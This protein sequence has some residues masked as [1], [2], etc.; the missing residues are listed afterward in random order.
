MYVIISLPPPPTK[1]PYY[2]PCMTKT[3]SESRGTYI[4]Y[5]NDHQQSCFRRQCPSL[6]LLGVFSIEATDAHH[7]KR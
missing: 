4:M 7:Y 1:V 2:V 5:L 3:R 6:F